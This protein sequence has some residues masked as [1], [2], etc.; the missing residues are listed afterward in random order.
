MRRRASQGRYCQY[1]DGRGYCCTSVS[2][3]GKWTCSKHPPSPGNREGLF[4]GPE[5]SRQQPG[6]WGGMAPQMQEV[7][8]RMTEKAAEIAAKIARDDPQKKE[9]IVE[10]LMAGKPPQEV[11]PEVAP[12]LSGAVPAEMQQK[13]AE[14]SAATA[15]KA[16]VEAE[17]V[18]SKGKLVALE[19]DKTALESKVKTLERDLQ[20]KDT[21][22]AQLLAVPSAAKGTTIVEVKALQDNVNDLKAKLLKAEKEKSDAEKNLA[23]MTTERD[24]ALSGRAAVT[25]AKDAALADIQRATDEK[26]AA[27]ADVAKLKGEKDSAIVAAQ[28]FQAERD[29]ATAANQ[30]IVDAC[31]IEKAKAQKE[32]QE[33]AHREAKASVDLQEATQKLAEALAR[34]KALQDTISDPM[35]IQSY[36]DL[37]DKFEQL[38]T[39]HAQMESELAAVKAQL[40]E[41]EKEITEHLKK[42]SECETYAAGME[43]SIK[44]LRGTV[45]VERKSLSVANDEQLKVSRENVALKVRAEDA[46]RKLQAETERSADLENKKVALEAERSTLAVEKKTLEAEIQR[47]TGV[48]SDNNRE[49][50]RLAQLISDKDSVISAKDAEIGRLQGS[51]S[52]SA[53]G[54]DEERRLKDE[55]RRLKEVA[56]AEKTNL[57]ATYNALVANN[58]AAVRERDAFAAEISRKN[59]T[60]GKL[61]E[62]ISSNAATILEANR[63]KD[64]AVANRDSLQRLHEELVAQNEAVVKERDALSAERTQLSEANVTLSLQNIGLT[65]AKDALAAEKAQLVA[66]KGAIESER[67]SAQERVAELQKAV[68][69]AAGNY[70]LL[71][72]AKGEVDALKTACD[73]DLQKSK[74][75]ESSLKSQLSQAQEDLAECERLKS[76]CTQKLGISAGE[77]GAS[78][79]K[80]KD[81]E[82]EVTRQE[83]L[84]QAADTRIKKF[85]GEVDGLKKSYAACDA[86]LKQ[87]QADAAKAGSA[88]QSSVAAMQQNIARLTGLISTKDAELATLQSQKA[89]QDTTLADAQRD[90]KD[91]NAKLAKLQGEYNTL[92]SE[93]DACN[94][95]EQTTSQKIADLTQQLSES[96]TDYAELEAEANQRLTEDAQE[97]ARLKAEVT[98]QGEKISDLLNRLSILEVPKPC[99]D[100][101]KFYEVMAN[102]LEAEGAYAEKINAAAYK[103]VDPEKKKVIDAKIKVPFNDIILL[104]NTYFMPDEADIHDPAHCN[105]LAERVRDWQSKKES[106]KLSDIHKTLLNIFEDGVGAVRV[107]VRVKLLSDKAIPAAAIT[108]DPEKAMITMTKPYGPFYTV[109]EEN[110]DNLAVYLG[111]TKPDNQGRRLSGPEAKVQGVHSVF[112]QIADGYTVVL[113]GYGLSGSGKSYTLFGKSGDP[114]TPGIV[115]IGLSQMRNLQYLM[116]AGIFELY[117][118]KTT[119]HEKV[120]GSLHVLHSAK[121]ITGRVNKAI[122]DYCAAMGVEQKIEGWIVRETAEYKKFIEAQI[123][124]ID[125]LSAGDID[126]LVSNTE[127]YRLQKRIKRVKATP[128][129]KESSRSHLIYIFAIGFA[130]S[131][132]SGYLIVMDMAGKEDPV[133][134]KS[135]FLSNPSSISIGMLMAPGI[136]KNPI[137]TRNFIETPVIAG[138]TNTDSYDVE[139]FVEM[140]REGIYINETIHQLSCFLVRQ[141]G[142]VYQSPLEMTPAVEKEKVRLGTD[143]ARSVTDYL[144]TAVFA[145]PNTE[146]DNIELVKNGE[147]AKKPPPLK[148]MTLMLPMLGFFKTLSPEN[149]PTKFVMMCNIRQ[150]KEFYEQ[151]ENTLQFADIIKST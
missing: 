40:A 106:T 145:N 43:T 45:D 84:V 83:G 102:S 37:Y 12:T 150:E 67:N 105:A 58:E 98:Q 82:L 140:L 4:Y 115:Q 5:W 50:Q 26:D 20:K 92:E 53:A 69:D 1:I 54:I 136:K 149:K 103:V 52:V 60:I 42:I 59:I 36:K 23:I 111:T 38:K 95:R 135:I 55:E 151:T 133:K 134:Y 107:Y 76:E 19:A 13:L 90:L 74:E 31:D 63:L 72:E 61:E 123:P 49:M 144:P 79:Q 73:S 24:T 128:L 71:E 25:Q 148:S 85:E 57:E 39:D 34:E 29:A 8:M 16:A 93:A 143:K 70:K 32:L 130:N 104:Q 109:F 48:I 137:V 28:K 33:A 66:E 9:K 6:P 15:H 51:V 120:V 86:A 117:T 81:L 101:V 139:D 97:I 121:F 80:V 99:A 89:A 142:G 7:V 108:V 122:A 132:T 141:G 62:I 10:A 65:Q 64:T 44:A 119:Q 91:E 131:G 2:T 56:M 17:L 124:N 146:Y 94:Q 11:L 87:M 88:Q 113:F 126:L 114:S 46:E 129:N 78:K 47:L 110:Y 100:V 35:K 27:L 21:E 30:G 18:T 138:A 116:V 127:R 41:K 75:I 118:K 68:S 77:L 125:A 3:P 22:I 14:V 112:S 147:A 96:K